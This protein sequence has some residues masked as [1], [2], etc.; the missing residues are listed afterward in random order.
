M[1]TAELDPLTIATYI[2]LAVSIGALWA[3]A[4]LWIPA[5]VV[6]VVLGYV[7]GVLS[8]LA[9]LWIGALA[10]ACWLYRQPGAVARVVSTITIAALALQL[11]LHVLPGFHNALMA[12]DVVLS[13]GAAPYDLYLNFDK[14]LVGL[15][16]IGLAWR[17]LI[18]SRFEL[19]AALRTA[20]PLIAINIVVLV[21]LSLALGYLR[22]DPKWNSFFWLWATANLLSTC[23]S[24]EAFFRAFIQG[25]LTRALGSHKH[26]VAI[27][28]AASAVIFGAA[29][30][31]G[32]WTYV[33][34]STVA[35]CGYGWIFHRTGRIE[36][37]MLAHF[38]M[39]A[40]HFLLFTYPFRSG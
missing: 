13:P 7:S 22:F 11:G 38:A 15:L 24:E 29:H 33:L 8:G 34:L 16:F 30:L 10:F 14:T 40:T 36:M 17:G 1:H 19:F 3:S 31:A 37:S 26:G 21:A 23:L 39:N 12:N 18:R 32:G 20:A 6:A 27:A 25:G 5:L 9:I 2:A 4:L 35:G 28:L